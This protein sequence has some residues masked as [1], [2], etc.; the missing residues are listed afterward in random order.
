MI[1]KNNSPFCVKEVHITHTQVSLRIT[2]TT[3][4][5]VTEKENSLAGFGNKE[6]VVFRTAEQ[7]KLQT[8]PWFANSTR[9]AKVPL[10]WRPTQR[11]LTVEQSRLA[12]DQ[13]NIAKLVLGKYHERRVQKP[14]LGEHWT[15]CT[16]R[17][18]LGHSHSRI[19]SRIVCFA[20]QKGGWNPATTAIANI[21]VPSS[22]CYSAG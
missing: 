14:I 15:G 8:R 10:M 5:Y 2:D 17:F 12:P 1:Y 20:C 21:A 7:K 3:K 6:I 11:T 19:N 9:R 16:I 4:M 18:L 13:R 22:R